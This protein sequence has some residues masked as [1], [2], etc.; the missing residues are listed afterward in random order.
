MWSAIVIG[1]M[2]AVLSPP[3]TALCGAGHRSCEPSIDE[4]RMKIERL[5]DSAFLTSHSLGTLEKLDGRR[6]E[7]QDRKIFEV[8]FSVVVNYSGDKLRCRIPLCPELHNYLVE[9]DEAAKTATIAGWLFF[10]QA[11]QGWR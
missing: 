9:V 10:E 6:V 5:L 11:D 3:A 1:L 2:T 4:V 7:T 8:R